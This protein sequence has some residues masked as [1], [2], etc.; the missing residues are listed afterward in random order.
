MT[1]P[2]QETVWICGGI[3]FGAM[4]G[5]ILVVE[6]A[7]YGLKSSGAASRA[8]LA[9]TIDSIGFKSSMADL[10]IWLRQMVRNIM[11]TSYAM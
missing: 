1:A 8:Y 2:C 6:K 4:A 9:E 5:K 11:S 10:D 3:E 7:L